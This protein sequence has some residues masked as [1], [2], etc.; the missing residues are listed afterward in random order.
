MI[1]KKNV[2]FG[3]L[4]L[5]LT[6]ALGIVMVNM[7]EDFGK[8]ALEKQTSVGRLQQLK[9]NSFEEELEPLNARQIAM[10]NTDGILSLN[11]LGNTEMSIDSIKGGAHAHGNLEALLNV[12]VGLALCFLA[13]SSWLKQ[14]IS[15]LFILGTLLHSGMLYL[16]RVF[17]LTWAESLLGTGIGPIMILAGLFIIGIAAVIG[18]RGEIIKD[19]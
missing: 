14:L 18:F 9:E 4:Y 19:N 5:V 16:G 6:A 13:V 7:Y 8:A 17:D 1:G 10:A 12:V 11:K 2:I 15:W 3:F